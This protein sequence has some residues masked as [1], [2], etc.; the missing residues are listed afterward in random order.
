MAAE[1]KDSHNIEVDKNKRS[2][3]GNEEKRGK[4]LFDLIKERG[5][6]PEAEKLRVEIEEVKKSR[7]E[8]I[9]RVK[10]LRGRINYK[11]NES[12]TIAK[13]LQINQFG[14][15]EKYLKEVRMLNRQKRG[16][17]FKISTG[18]FSLSEE[19]NIIRKV[20]EIDNSIDEMMRVVRLFR[21]K[22]LIKKDLETYGT[23]LKEID[24]K[25][26][27]MDKQLDYLYSSLRKVLK[28]P[29]KKDKERE[30]IG[31][32]RETKI[33]NVEVNLEDIVVIKKK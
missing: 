13:L 9:S 19:K 28:V 15:Q 11:N 14:D 16:L 26:A 33:N 29:E 23:E 30:N 18:T 5:N 17:D 4:S 7:T 6:P 25:I 10:W 21:K 27:V 22:D 12:E 31:R 1:S 2:F 32:R 8:L 24:E 3:G 20:K